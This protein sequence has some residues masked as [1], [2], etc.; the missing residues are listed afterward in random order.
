MV[1]DGNGARGSPGESF[2]THDVLRRRAMHAGNYI[3]T[4]GRLEFLGVH[5][6]TIPA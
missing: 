6:A 1:R 3:T 5:A 4:A 2:L